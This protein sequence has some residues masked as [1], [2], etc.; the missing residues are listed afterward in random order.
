MYAQESNQSTARTQ[1]ESV[2]NSLVDAWGK[3]DAELF[4]SNFTEDADF[5]VWFGMRLHGREEIAFGHNI[6][7]KEFYANTIWDLKIDKIRFIGTDHAL[8]HCSGSVI[9]QGETSPAEP[10]AVP[11]LVFQK[12]DDTWKIIS[13]QNTPYAV[14]EFRSNGDIRRMKKTMQKFKN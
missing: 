10:D 7:F 9:K 6:I 14:N 13:L 3:G 1:I 5:T 2:L 12:N 8:V 11:L 4:A